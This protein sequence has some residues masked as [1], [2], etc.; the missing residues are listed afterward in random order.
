[1][2]AGILSE[3]GTEFGP[4]ENPCE[5][6]DCR[7]TR[8]MAQAACSIC[9]LEIGYGTRFYNERNAP[10]HSARPNVFVHALCLEKQVE[11]PAKTA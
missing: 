4:C 8:E 1:M 11:R 6:S 2:A 3:P 5:H 7:I 10:G 9:G